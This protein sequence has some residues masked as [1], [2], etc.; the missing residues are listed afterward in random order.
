MPRF[1]SALSPALRVALCLALPAQAGPAFANEFAPGGDSGT[2]ARAFALPV[3]GDAQLL[4]RGRTETRWTLDFANEYVAE[5]ECAVECIVL[6]GE[7]ARLRLAHRRGLGAGWDFGFE[8]PLLD[9]GGGFLDGWIQDWHDAFGLPTG[10]RELAV[11]D[12]YLFHYERQG[13]ALFDETGGGAGLGDVTLTL[14]RHFGRAGVLR[15]MAKLQTGD[16]DSLEGG[17]AGGA[18]WLE[19]ACALAP[20]VGGYLALGVTHGGRGPLL[21]DEQNRTIGFGGL[22]LMIPLTRA[23]RLAAQLQAH[24]RF[25]DGSTLTPLQRAGAPLTLGL[26]I[27]TGARGALELGFQEDPS[28]NGSPDFVAYLSFRSTSLLGTDP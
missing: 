16:E 20:R 2:L 7:T 17:V 21:P 24:S 23:V 26:E 3:L 12:R 6:D 1:A 14:G 25:Y 28:V 8:L 22:G 11:H 13:V 15:A 19:R 10:G 9:R 4:A 5:G 18:L 27:R